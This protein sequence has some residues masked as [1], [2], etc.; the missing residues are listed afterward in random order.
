MDPTLAVEDGHQEQ[1][2]GGTHAAG[3]AAVLHLNGEPREVEYASI[4]FSAL[5]NRPRRSVKKQE[6]AET[7][8]AEVKREKKDTTAGSGRV[9]DDAKEEEEE[10]DKDTV[11]GG[12][13]EEGREE[14]SVYSSVKDALEQL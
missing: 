1:A 13:G 5:I 8:Y 12:A 6:T 14:E 2:G 11:G 10:E 3:K 7:E 4:D 9:E